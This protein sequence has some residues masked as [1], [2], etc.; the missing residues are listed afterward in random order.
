MLAFAGY[1]V[2]TGLDVVLARNALNKAMSG[3]YGAAATAGRSVLFLSAAVSVFVFPTFVEGRGD[4]SSRRALWLAVAAAAGAGA[5][6]ASTIAL[7]PSLPIRV[8]YGDGYGGAAGIIGLTAFSAAGLG[9]VNILIHYHIAR[10]S[11]LSMLPWVAVAVAGVAISVDPHPT[12]TSIALTMVVVTG[13]AVLAMA[14]PVAV[15][16]AAGPLML[17]S[18]VYVP[19]TSVLD[20]N[21]EAPLADV[22]SKMRRNVASVL[23]GVRQRAKGRSA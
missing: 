22:G 23:E 18:E 8:L 5:V 12:P 14:L 2:Y 16:R 4:A 3:D 6:A 1:W 17:E 9:V 11:I 15:S 13:V 20:A 7:L 19:A 21:A 10:Q